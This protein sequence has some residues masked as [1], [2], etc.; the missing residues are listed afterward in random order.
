MLVVKKELKV[1]A[2]SAMFNCVTFRGKPEEK[3]A[4]ECVNFITEP[5]YDFWEAYKR[6]ERLG[7]ELTVNKDKMIYP[8][9]FRMRNDKWHEKQ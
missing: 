5:G 8:V 1:E 3:G 7:E 6:R 2:N 9:V 4:K